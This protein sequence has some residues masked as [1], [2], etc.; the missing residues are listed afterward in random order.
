VIR[1]VVVKNYQSLRSVDLELGSFTVIVGP[2]SS[3]KSALVRA[4]R[5]L[6][7][8]SRGA[9]Y[10]SNGQR[11]AS[12]SA[13][14]D[15]GSVVTIERGASTGVY[16]V[17]HPELG[18]KEFSKLGG[19]VPELVTQVLR[20]A[21][22]KDGQSVNFAGQFDRPYL[23]DDSGAQ[24]AR[25]LGELTNVSVVFEAAREAN[26]RRLQSSSELRTREADLVTLVTQLQSFADLP[27]AIA[28]VEAAERVVQELQQLA[29]RSQELER[30]VQALA[31]AETALTQARSV[32]PTPQPDLSELAESLERL[33]ALEAVLLA[34]VTATN[35]AK[36]A[37]VSVSEARV[38]TEEASRQLSAL[39]VELGTCPVCG[40]ESEHMHLASV[41]A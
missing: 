41:V 18:G 1:R 21:P 20:I 15:D 19:D 36:Q 8:N 26:R 9:S 32:R 11:H 24:V 34:W 35:A 17:H 38:Q 40:A 6:A 30:E 22:V 4:L 27:S 23:M 3:G 28:R 33:E 39:M 16:R 5:T 31:M 29:Q 7:S 13:H 37:S 2:S 10:V 14:L 25:T 12:V